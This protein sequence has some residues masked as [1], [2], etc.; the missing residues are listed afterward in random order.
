MQ[1]HYDIT[2]KIKL[3]TRIVRNCTRTLTSVMSGPTL[4]SINEAGGTLSAVPGEPWRATGSHSFLR[5][6]IRTLWRYLKVSLL[7]EFLFQAK[8]I[9]TKNHVFSVIMNFLA[10]SM[11]NG[12]E[13][14][15]HSLKRKHMDPMRTTINENNQNQTNMTCPIT[16]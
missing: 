15:R 3:W 2:S 9:F 7:R 5:V 4:H 14:K 1:N 11:S 13:F 16:V 8:I 6:Y 12:A 10:I